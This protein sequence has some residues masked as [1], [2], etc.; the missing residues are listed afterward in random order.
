MA[1]VLRTH[2]WMYA[3]RSGSSISEISSSWKEG[4]ATIA[5]APWKWARHMSSSLTAHATVDM[6]VQL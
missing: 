1:R 5:R 4:G 3:A 6:C 2:V